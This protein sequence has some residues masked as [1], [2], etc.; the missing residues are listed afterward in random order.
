M[1]FGCPTTSLGPY[2]GNSLAHPVLISAIFILDSKVTGS[3]VSGLDNSTYEKLFFLTK[4]IRFFCSQW[5]LT[6]A[7]ANESKYWK[8]VFLLHLQS[9]H[10][11]TL[12]PDCGYYYKYLRVQRLALDC[13][14][15]EIRCI[16]KIVW[17]M[18]YLIV[19]SVVAPWSRCF[20]VKLQ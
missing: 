12:S 2:R 14:F 18:R 10:W 3:H 11:A 17:W 15:R 20:T 8:A 16:E 7:K 5:H 19:S 1:L 4:I 6:I 9:K 13:L